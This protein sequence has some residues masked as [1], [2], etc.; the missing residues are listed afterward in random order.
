MPN[1]NA[2]YTAEFG[3]KVPAISYVFTFFLTQMALIIYQN[4]Q[5]NTRDFIQQNSI[6]SFD[7]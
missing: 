5:K 4:Y 7:Y 3:N 1:A 6:Q 2:A